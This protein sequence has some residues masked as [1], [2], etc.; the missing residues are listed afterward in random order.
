M[1]LINILKQ[2]LK[3]DKEKT[4][5]SYKDFIDK[6]G[7][8]DLRRSVVTSIPGGI[9][10]EGDL[11]LG[12]EMDRLP[13][14][15]RIKGDLDARQSKISRFPNW[16]DIGGDFNLLGRNNIIDI[17]R[18]IIVRGTLFLPKDG[19][20]LAKKYPVETLKKI[21]PNVKNIEIA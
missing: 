7:N 10:I 9:Y 4:S 14:S 18:D 2:V 21:F 20:S 8:I 13:N 12:Y 19:F 3:E 15:L 1:K 16:L 5:K 6:R 11:I 17:P